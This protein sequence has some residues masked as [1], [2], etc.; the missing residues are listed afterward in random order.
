LEPYTE[1]LS[2]GR[3]G[4]GELSAAPGSKPKLVSSAP[5]DQ[6]KGAA[7]S[8]HAI[9]PIPALIKTVAV[10][11]RVQAAALPQ[12]ETGSG[13]NPGETT[14]SSRGAGTGQEPSDPDFPLYV[15]LAQ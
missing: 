10:L 8:H 3:Q 15:D 11:D 14:S 7:V 4:E 5:G 13:A 1:E 6:V 9:E 2:S 12:T